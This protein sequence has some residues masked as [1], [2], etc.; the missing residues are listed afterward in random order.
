MK[1][2]DDT[3]ATPT[4][5][6]GG[7]IVLTCKNCG[8]KFKRSKATHLWNLKQG[9]KLWFCTQRCATSYHVGDKNPSWKPDRKKLKNHLKTLRM[10]KRMDDWRLFIFQRD[11]F[12][13]QMCGDRARKGHKVVLNAHHIKRFAIYPNLRFKHNNGITLCVGCHKSIRGKEEKYEY[14]FNNIVKMKTKKE[15]K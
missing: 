11:N 6:R 15:K 7:E 10:S 13:C 2:K 14:I 3:E 8:K 12:Q 9:T 4:K 1:K 5:E